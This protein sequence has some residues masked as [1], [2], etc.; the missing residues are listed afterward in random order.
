MKTDNNVNISEEAN[1][2]YKTQNCNNHD[3]SSSSVNCYNHDFL[4]YKIM[5]PPYKFISYYTLD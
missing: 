1:M 5:Y 3:I 2:T 4:N